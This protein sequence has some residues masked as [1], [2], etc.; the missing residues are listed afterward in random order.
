MALSGSISEAGW[1]TSGVLWVLGCMRFWRQQGQD[2]CAVQGRGRCGLGL[3][4]TAQNPSKFSSKSLHAASWV[5]SGTEGWLFGPLGSWLRIASVCRPRF[6]EA[7]LSLLSTHPAADPAG[8]GVERG[9]LPG[10]KPRRAEV[11]AGR[12]AGWELG[13]CVARRGVGVRSGQELWFSSPAA[14]LAGPVGA[15]PVASPE[16]RPRLPPSSF[17]SLGIGGHFLPWTVSTL[18]AQDTVAG[19]LVAHLTAR[20]GLCSILRAAAFRSAPAL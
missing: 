3:A 17:S 11:I 2:R 16:L 20:W 12:W 9:Q 13:E 1:A 14:F 18:G 7:G 19:Q 8:L 4:T 10:P 5:R 15:P 6:E